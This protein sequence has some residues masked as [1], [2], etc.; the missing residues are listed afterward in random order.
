MK[1]LNAHRNVLK[2]LETGDA[3]IL[4]SEEKGY[5]DRIVSYRNGNRAEW[6][7]ERIFGTPSSFDVIDHYVQTDNYKLD[8]YYG[9]STPTMVEKQSSLN[10]L[11]E[12][13]FTK[14]IMGDPID[15]FDKFVEDWLKLGGKDITNEVNDWYAKQ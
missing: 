3:S 1:N 8:S 12:E 13:V 11:E 15:S 2:A 5:Y 14:I 7:Q 9:G 10:K 6:G 4:N